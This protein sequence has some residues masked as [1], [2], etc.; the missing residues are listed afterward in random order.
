VTLESA[1]YVGELR[2]RRF[3]PKTH[4]FSYPVYMA[5]LDVD[6]LPEL[7]RVSALSSYNRWNITAYCER[8]HFGNPEL[9]LRARLAADAARRGI[10]LPDGQIFVLTH[11]RYLG[12]VFNP[13]SFYYLYDRAGELAML[14]AEVNST[15]GESHNYWLTPRCQRASS[16]AK[17]YSTA[18]EMHVS[19]FMGMHL[20][21]D[22][23]FTAPGAQLVAHM[24]TLQDG[25]VF[26]DATLEL[27]RRPW[28][29]PALR[30]VLARYPLMTLRVIAGIHWQALRLWQ[31]GVPVFASSRKQTRDV[32][33]RL[34]GAGPVATSKGSPRG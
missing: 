18:K 30:G 27:T 9:P 13:V 7:M 25:K 21:Y 11:L 32:P 4:A 24:N 14:M 16:T 19:P 17:R 22:W 28:Q 10:Q 15:F 20:D 3:T 23:A 31:K 2:H 12:Y 34:V 29:A 26:F 6:G 5:F 33:E 8:D 1:L